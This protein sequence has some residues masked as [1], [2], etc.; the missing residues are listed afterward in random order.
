MAQ[1]LQQEL[2]ELSVSGS[3]LGCIGH[4]WTEKVPKN[5]MLSNR[6][7]VSLVNIVKSILEEFSSQSKD[8]FLNSIKK[9]SILNTTSNILF[10]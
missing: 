7:D 9:T 10:V 2:R 5:K 1:Q 3:R 8:T 4:D 6:T